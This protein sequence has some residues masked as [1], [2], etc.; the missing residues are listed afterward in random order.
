MIA[1]AVYKAGDQNSLSRALA[2]SGKLEAEDHDAIGLRFVW[3]NEDRTVLARISLADGELRLETNSRERLAQAKEL[4]GGIGLTKLEHVRDEF[5]SAEELK[6]KAQRDMQEGVVPIRKEL[7][8]E[9]QRELI[10][11]YLEDYYAK[12][13]DTKIPGLGGKTP[14]EAAR[15]ASG[16]LE[17]LD[18][19]HTIENGEERKRLAGH[20]LYDVAKLYAELGLKRV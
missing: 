5:Q 3:L 17:L 19:L 14:R 9:S 15:S 6:Q 18:I 11:E 12:W 13:P 7:P 1:L 4:L 10:S 20:V 2:E 8:D 16:S